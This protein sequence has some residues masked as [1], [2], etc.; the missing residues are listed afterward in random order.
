V[1]ESERYWSI[2]KTPAS[3]SFEKLTSCTRHEEFLGHLA[4]VIY[5]DPVFGETE[6]GMAP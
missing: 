5:R 6:M 4:C 3:S 2:K 1:L